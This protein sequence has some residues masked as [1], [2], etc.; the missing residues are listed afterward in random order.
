MAHVGFHVGR[1]VEE[2]GVQGAGGGTGGGTGGLGPHCPV[3][4]APH[5]AGERQITL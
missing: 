5:A 2:P 4:T 1:H 3:P